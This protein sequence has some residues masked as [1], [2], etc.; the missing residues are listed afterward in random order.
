MSM[1][2]KAQKLLA[3]ALK[4]EPGERAFVAVQLIAS[5]DG[6]PD[7]AAEAAWAAE[8]EKRALLAKAGK[9]QARDW[10]E[11]HDELKRDL[12]R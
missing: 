10:Q 6:E 2:D 9:S 7:E 1:T 3:E 4:L 12:A 8:I 5:V 11:V